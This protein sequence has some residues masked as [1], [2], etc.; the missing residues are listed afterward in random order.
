MLD[1]ME[2]TEQIRRIS[3]VDERKC[4]KC[5]RCSASCPS[6]DEMD[7]RPHQFVSYL[8]S[9]DL[10]AMSN[11][12]SI[13]KCLSCF[14]CVERCPRDVKPAKLIE[15]VRL[16]VIRQQGADYLSPDDIPELLDP[17]LPQ[18]LLA[19]AFRKYAK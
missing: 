19:S 13:W 18:Q 15:A 5:G 6:I 10:D 9:G 2:R 1:K 12:K 14:A 11:S 8:S 17:E 7:V 16:A 3:G 4:M